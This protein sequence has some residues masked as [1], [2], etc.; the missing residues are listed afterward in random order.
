M[1][2]P[3]TPED[4]RYELFVNNAWTDITSKVYNRDQ[5]KLTRGFSSEKSKDAA[6]PAQCTFTV[7]NRN[8]DFSPRNPLGAYYGSLGQNTPVRI[9]TRV[10]NDDF[11]RTVSNGWGSTTPGGN[12]SVLGTV[13]NYAVGGGKGTHSIASVNNFRITY[14]SDYTYRN[15]EVRATCT[16]GIANVAGGTIQPL[17]L[18]V[19]GLSTTDYF[20]MSVTI[21][22]AEVISVRL[23]HVDGTEIAASVNLGFANTGQTLAAA[24]Q[25]EGQ[26]LRGKVWDASGP[27]PHDW[28]LQGSFAVD[29]YIGRAPGWVGVRS[30]VGAGSTN[31]PVTFSYD[32]FEVRVNRLHGECASW[33]AEWDVSGND[34]YCEVEAA[35]LRRRL[36]QG[37]AP[38]TS[39]VRRANETQAFTYD[40]GS[41][42]HVLYYPVEDENGSTTIASGLS[43]VGPMDITGPGTPQLASDSSFVG[44]AP[45]GKP[46][47]SRW[48]SPFITTPAT[49]KVQV[50]FVLSVPSTGETDLAT[51]TQLTCSGS[52]GFVDIFYHAGAGGDLEVNFYDQGRNLITGSGT[53]DANIN[54]EPLLITLFM[55]QNGSN[56]DWEIDWL[57]LSSGAAIGIFGSVAG[58]TI[59]SPRRILASPYTQVS[60]SAI[61]HI[62]VRT[63]IISI[64]SL[65]TMLKGYAGEYVTSRVERLCQ[66]ND[67]I[68]I[69]SYQSSILAF[70][71]VG[72]QG[73]KTLLQLLDEAVKADLGTLQESRD[74]VGFTH[75]YGRALYNQDAA[76]TLDYANGDLVMPFRQAN[77]D[78]LIV[79][80]YTASREGGG[81]YRATQDTGPMAVTSPSSGQGVG[82]YPD[83]DTY[84][85][86]IDDQLPDIATWT[87]HVGTSE[88]PRYPEVR[89]NLAK[90]AAANW[91][92]YLNALTIDLDDRI[93]IVNPKATIINGTISQLVKGYTETLASKQH[94]IAFVCAPGVPFEVAEASADTGDT[95]PWLARADTDDSEVAAAA[96]AGA[97]SLK[98]ATM[99]DPS[100]T[101]IADDYPLYLDVGGIQVRATAITSE[102]ITNTGFESGLAGWT[103]NGLSSFTQS[104]TQKHSGG[105][106]ARLVPDGVSVNGGIIGNLVAVRPGQPVTVS[107]WAWFTNL[108][109][110]NYSMAINWY[111]ASQAYIT[112]SLTLRSAAAATW[113]QD[114]GTYTA[115]ANAAFAAAVPLLAGTPAAGQIWYA[116]DISL[117]GPQ[118]FTVDALPVARAAGLSVSAWHLP[119]LAQ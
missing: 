119:V 90:L 52:I 11:V 98:V 1:V 117:T 96:L 42:P 105:F 72:V 27:E 50:M 95:N 73:R 35:G 15:V 87:V 14:L 61:G 39:P 75:R 97:T 102:N 116:D 37:E 53:A 94:E 21:S 2:F 85:V 69:A 43:N 38:L 12:W 115:P 48:S 29:A 16:T 110:A 79:N 3:A 13:G 76:L 100:W 17:N 4:T 47:N 92:Q 118:T 82:R 63:D 45:I 7:N 24:L 10:C 84:N 26:V 54:G 89:V 34:V 111:D 78:Q 18:I 88:E 64:F 93:E 55:T 70:T 30:G 99:T 57:K 19:S 5:V 80:D 81:T 44:S 71:Q 91:Q 8:G 51:F 65:I 59:G 6:T 68:P 66:E 32:S 22:T 113:T 62:A 106:G 67:S 41:P 108:V 33:P 101:T 114:S 104:A 25:L 77:D 112:T 107:G 60:N 31:I 36:Q 9:L 74:I 23:N 56:V 83:G 49:G 86:Y 28:T 46:N 20:M 103:P 109:T 58:R 40:P